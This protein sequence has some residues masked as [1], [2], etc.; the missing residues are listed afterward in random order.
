MV[1]KSQNTLMKS[2]KSADFRGKT[3]I[4]VALENFLHNIWACCGYLEGRPNVA[5]YSGAKITVIRR[6]DKKISAKRL[7]GVIYP[8]QG[9]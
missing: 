9:S 2:L 6:V 1:L 7:G 8:P 3:W 4:L 5:L